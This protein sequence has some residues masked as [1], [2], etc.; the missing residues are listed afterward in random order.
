MIFLSMGN[1]AGVSKVFVA[2]LLLVI[3]FRF[4]LF[5]IYFFNLKWLIARFGKFDPVI[6]SY[7]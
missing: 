1:A 5:I 6:P 7:L 3:I 4:Y 2:E